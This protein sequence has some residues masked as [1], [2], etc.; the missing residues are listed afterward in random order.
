MRLTFTLRARLLMLAVVSAGGLLVLGTLDLMQ[1]RQAQLAGYRVMLRN[2]VDTAHDTVAYFHGEWKAG[3]LSEDEAKQKARDALRSVRYA[4]NEYI[5]VTGFDGTRVVQPAKPE[6]EGTKP[7]S[8]TRDVNGV[9]IS[10]EIIAAARN[11]GGFVEY[12]YPRLGSTEP[13]PKLS[14]ATPFAPWEWSIGTGVYVDDVDT[15]F[16]SG[17]RT[18]AGEALALVALV[19]GGAF[20][21]GRQIARTVN[22]IADVMR[23][24]AAG[25]LDVAVPEEDRRDEFGTMTAALRVFKTA[26]AENQ[27]LLAEQE[28][29]K[30]EAREQERVSLL[31]MADDVQGRVLSA[32]G[33]IADESQRLSA[34][35]HTLSESAQETRARSTTVSAAT[36]QTTANVETVAAAAEQ[37]SA[38]SREIGQQVEQSAAVAGRAMD[39]AAQTVSTVREL[40]ESTKRIGEVADLISGIAAQTNLLALNATIEAAR[41]GEAGKGFAVVASEVKNLANQTAGATEEISRIIQSVA[42]GTQATV[43][44][45]ERI[46]ATI[47]GINDTASA[48]A[49]AVEEQNAATGNIAGSVHEAAAGTR[50]IAAEILQVSTSAQ[51]T[52]DT[53]EDVSRA[54]RLLDGEAIALKGQI[55]AFVDE[56]RTAANRA[57]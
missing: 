51:G 33:R 6:S 12:H 42:N 17:A 50:R 8:E 18:L 45:I 21:L 30:R 19:T 47:R 4:G 39:E 53:A 32:V 40:A 38:S 23:R 13:A 24:L 2:V 54:S 25:D 48:I 20:L 16:W 49:A 44:A 43:G 57:V 3:R 9:Y 15:A 14:Y 55:Q 35:S 36:G 1:I 46:E 27:A 34:A 52:M 22:G 28:R 26:T 29:L 37:L 41:A 11:G 31:R 56:L 5:F 7:E 10:R